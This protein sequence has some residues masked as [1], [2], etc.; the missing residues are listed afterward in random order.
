[1]KEYIEGIGEVEA[2]RGF[3]ERAANFWYHYKW[4]SVVALVLVFA[5]LIC[6]LQFCKKEDYDIHVLYAGPYVV[7]KTVS[8][9]SEAEV[10]K[11][12]SSLNRVAN[13]FDTDGSVKVNFTNYLYMSAEEMQ[14]A[15]SNV[16]YSF[17]SNDKKSLEGSLDYS[18]YYLC[19][20]SPAVYEAYNEMGDI[21]MFMPLDEYSSYVSEEA[22]Y[23]SNAIKLSKTE[24]YKMPGISA[25]PDD[26][27]LCVKTP[28]VLASKSKEHEDYLS[29]AK[30]TLKNILVLSPQPL[31]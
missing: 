6:S 24:F 27:L 16:D 9:G 11:V 5:V 29:R 22:Y 19:F 3:K 7:G 15:C 31:E 14:A 10:E 20:I 12:I 4:H 30:E 26:T 8:D 2:P 23:A 18:E 17:L 21:D 1:M 25:L 28:S 13:D